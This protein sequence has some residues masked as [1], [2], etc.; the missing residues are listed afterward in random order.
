MSAKKKGGGG[1]G[2]GGAPWV[3]TF[4]D[5]MSLLMALFVMIV[6]FSSQDEQKLQEAAGSIRDAFGYQSV[7]RPA[8]MIEQNGLPERKYLR[9]VQPMSLSEAVEFANDFNDQYEK[10]GPEV[11]TNRFEKAAESKPR[12]YLTASESL[13]QALQDLPDYAELS[14]QIVLSVA[15]DGLHISIIDQ[16]GRPMF[17]SQSS[18]PTDRMKILLSRIAPV[19]QQMPGRLQIIGH[20]ESTG[21]MAVPGGAAWALSAKRALATAE[22]LGSFGLGAGSLAQVIGVADKDPMFP[23]DPFLSGNRRIELVLLKEAPAMPSES[24]F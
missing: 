21:D 9:N 11:N 13:R 4:A 10:Q 18:E 22:I 16:D 3:I 2:H 8:G 20:T 24:P 17:A 14:K 1:G 15:N 5:L 7:Q 23:D 12:D 6:S 19:I